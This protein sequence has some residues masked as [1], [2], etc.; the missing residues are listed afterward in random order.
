M[1]SVILAA[2]LIALLAPPLQAADG[3]SGAWTSAGTAGQTYVF[4]VRGDQFTG[5]VCGPC[6]DPAAVFMI[7]DGKILDADR[8]TF[9]INYDVGGPQFK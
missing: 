9:S 6:D 3:L 5:I 2:A 4:K 1:K 7:E 8:L